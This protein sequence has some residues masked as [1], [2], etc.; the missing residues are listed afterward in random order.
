MNI[1]AIII[2]ET[3]VHEY[4]GNIGLVNKVYHSSI[5]V[6][7]CYICRCDSLEPWSYRSC[8]DCNNTVDSVLVNK[9][10]QSVSLY[11]QDQKQHWQHSLSGYF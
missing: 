3:T 6:I 8:L 2:F 10:I 7:H 9:I 1:L 11:T 4:S 5:L